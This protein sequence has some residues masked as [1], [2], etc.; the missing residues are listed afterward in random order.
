MKIGRR[1]GGSES[2]MKRSPTRGANGAKALLLIGAALSIC[3]IL[4]VFVW[5]NHNNNNYNYK[6]DSS[7]P[8]M[9]SLSKTSTFLSTV[10]TLYD[11]YGSEIQ[12]L[13]PTMRAWCNVSKSCKFTDF[14]VE[15]LYM[16]IREHKPQKVFEMAP[17]KGFS[18]HWILSALHKNNDASRLYSYDIHNTSLKFMNE[19]HLKDRWSFTLGDYEKLLQTGDLHMDGF[20]FIFID[21]LHTE[22]FS[23]GYCTK[24]LLPHKTQAIVAIHDIVADNLGGGRESA[25]VYKYMAMANNIQNVFTVSRF[26]MP[27]LLRPV[28]NAVE[29]LHHIRASHGI[30]KPCKGTTACQNAIHDPLYFENND[31]P[32]IFFQLN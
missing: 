2:S 14:E 26:G 8:I 31:A 20:D 19:K 3:F 9:G 16:L 18:S 29:K 22:A 28:D 6:R 25:E 1:I 23:R 12:A 24:L 17:N 11:K 30:G 32:T 15:M 27:S 4:F 13:R 7:I 5:S 10:T 21:A